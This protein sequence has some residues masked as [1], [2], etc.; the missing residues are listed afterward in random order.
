MLNR[1][2]FNGVVTVAVSGVEGIETLQETDA[3]Q[4]EKLQVQRG[5]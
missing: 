4:R 5:R 1:T 3:E 2:H